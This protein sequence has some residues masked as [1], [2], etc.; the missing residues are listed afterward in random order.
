MY[1]KAVLLNHDDQPVAIHTYNKK[2]KRVNR[3]QQEENGLG[4]MQ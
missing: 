1:R 3:V 4:Y 2:V